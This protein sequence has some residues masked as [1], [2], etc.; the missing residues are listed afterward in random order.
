MYLVVWQS[1]LLR[2]TIFSSWIIATRICDNL[3]KC[4]LHVHIW[5]SLVPTL[6]QVLVGFFNFV[7]SNVTPG[8]L[9]LCYTFSTHLKVSA[10][11]HYLEKLETFLIWKGKW[12]SVVLV[13][14]VK[15]NRV[16]AYYYWFVLDRL[17]YIKTQYFS[18]GLVH[19]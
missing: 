3:W 10:I 1:A 8:L 18:I 17:H 19:N 11:F 4:I 6:V 16:R 15:L 9:Q 13:Y 12:L 5:W 7:S 14:S 2:E